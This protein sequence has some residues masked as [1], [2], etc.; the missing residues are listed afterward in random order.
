MPH[1]DGWEMIQRLKAA[2]CTRRNEKTCNRIIVVQGRRRRCT[3]HQRVKRLRDLRK[4]Q[5]TFR[6]RRRRVSR[7]S[8]CGHAAG[9]VIEKEK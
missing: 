5:E 2:E 6:Q 8:R 9:T 3:E 7:R 4:S 1:M